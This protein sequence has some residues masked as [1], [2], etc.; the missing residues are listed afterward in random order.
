MT[1]HR[2]I[3]DIAELTLNVKGPDR[4]PYVTDRRRPEH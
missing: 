1:S 3:V 2:H 4:K